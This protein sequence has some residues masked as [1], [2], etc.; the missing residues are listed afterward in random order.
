MI[1]DDVV[2]FARTLVRG[3]FEANDRLEKKLDQEGWDGWPQFL[4]ALFFLAIG[5]QFKDRYDEGAVIRFVA[6]LRANNAQSEGPSI[7]QAEAESLIRAVFGSSTRPDLSSEAMGHI[8]THAVY[9]ILSQGNLTD[10]ELDDLLTRARS[11]ADTHI[12]RA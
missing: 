12:S 5:R 10:Q 9:A 7:N 8:Q 6:E 4:G 1:K 11:I 2:Q 3:D